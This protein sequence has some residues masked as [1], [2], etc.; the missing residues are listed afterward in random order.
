[1]HFVLDV[2]LLLKCPN[3]MRIKYFLI[4]ILCLSFGF[5]THWYL[6]YS[7]AESRLG[8]P[9]TNDIYT[10]I[11][12]ELV[13]AQQSVSK[14]NLDEYLEGLYLHAQEKGSAT[15][16][17]VEPG[18]DLIMS[19]T[20]DPERAVEFTRKMQTINALHQPA[21][22]PAE[23]EHRVAELF[24]EIEVAEQGSDEFNALVEDYVVVAGSL[25]PEASVAAM[26]QL[27]K[28]SP[29]HN[30]L[31]TKLDNASQV[32]AIPYAEQWLANKA[33]LGRDEIIQKLTQLA[34]RIV[35]AADQET[36]NRLTQEYLD[37]AMN[38]NDPEESAEFIELLTSYLPQPVGVTE[39]ALLP[40]DL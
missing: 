33:P 10:Q 12:D 17:E 29:E 1:M 39:Q 21:L 32:E 15:A 34:Q 36:Q 4:F 38:L 26:M 23:A 30:G 19:L 28:L 22:T 14:E 37:L 18:I 25:M 35:N 8:R 5:A 40:H 11:S 27:N 31:S 3:A 13:K 9:Q 7:G 2:C 16:L 6:N 20:G 24:R